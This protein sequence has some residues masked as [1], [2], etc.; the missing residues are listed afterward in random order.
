MIFFN[1]REAIKTS[2]AKRDVFI[3]FNLAIAAS[4]NLVL[5]VALIWQFWGFSEMIIL[6][7]TIYFGIS[8]LGKW[9]QVLLL[10][11]AGLIVWFLNLIL[12]FR[13]Y[14]NYRLL[15]YYL[16]AVA[17]LVNLMLVVLGGLLIY[18]NF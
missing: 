2:P 17:L 4:L 11:L 13:F 1:F 16:V 3:L 18:I 10:P 9:Y 12:A 6:G 8:A 7:Y 14:L 15:S 5:W